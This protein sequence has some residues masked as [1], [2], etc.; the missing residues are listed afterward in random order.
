ME[1][2]SPST[3][4]PIHEIPPVHLTCQQNRLTRRPAIVLSTRPVYFRAAVLTHEQGQAITFCEG[5]LQA[6][7]LR[8]DLRGAP[9]AAADA[10]STASWLLH[11]FGLQL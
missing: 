3:P 2:V 9:G 6:L 7:R 5:S 11:G 10:R 8:C 1:K 4:R